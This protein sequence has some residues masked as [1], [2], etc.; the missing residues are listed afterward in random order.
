MAEHIVDF[1]RWCPECK[2]RDL[3]PDNYNI[4]LYNICDECLKEPVN[5][6]SRKPCYFTPNEDK[7]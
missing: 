5:E 4:D 2:Y 3:E 7:E 1:H 6:D